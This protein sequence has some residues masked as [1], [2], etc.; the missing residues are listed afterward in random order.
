MFS[1]LKELFLGFAFGKPLP[2]SDSMSDGLSLGAYVQQTAYLMV[3]KNMN[4]G[5]PTNREAL[6]RSI[7]Q[8]AQDQYDAYTAKKS[9]APLTLELF[10]A[11][12]C[13]KNREVY[14]LPKGCVVWKE[15]DAQALISELRKPAIPVQ[16]SFIVR[17]LRRSERLDGQPVPRLQQP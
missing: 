11:S 4:L 14:V 2:P 17:S 16:E 5:L 9:G 7:V 13:M 8:D 6:M 3:D 12:A 15:G 10:V 1:R